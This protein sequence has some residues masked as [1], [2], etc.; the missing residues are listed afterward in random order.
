MGHIL[1][2]NEAVDGDL[3]VR[4]GQQFQHLFPDTLEPEVDAG[5]EILWEDADLI[6][7]SKPA[8]LPVHPCGR[9]N[10]NTMTSLLKCI[11]T[12]SD[13]RIV[14]RLD[15]NTTGVMLMSRTA[16]AATDLRRQFERSEVRK[17]YL[18]RCC[19]HPDSDGFSCHDSISRKRGKAGLRGVDP[20]GNPARTEFRVIRRSEDGT[21]LLRAVPLTGRTNQIRIHLW[22]MG[23]PV[24]G[25]PAYL[26]DGTQAASQTLRVDQAPM[27]LHAS[28]LS[29]RHPRTGAEI[30]FSAPDPSWVE[31]Y[32]FSG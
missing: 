14:H 23:M 11:Y 19:G 20:R 29:L 5:I 8:P 21:T 12:Q 15:A 24:L 32:D 30:E 9:F 25:D 7:V 13:L 10:L 28:S 2:D 26:R 18:V 22:S 3:R 27:C 17:S 16:G 6:A 31:Q 4:G 1:R